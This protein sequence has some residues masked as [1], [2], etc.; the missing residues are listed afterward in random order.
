[1][2]GAELA[3]TDW[4]AMPTGPLLCLWDSVIFFVMDSHDSLTSSLAA[5]LFRSL[6]ILQH[7]F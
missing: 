5:V 6:M 1:M 3:G 7:T 4:R 2:S